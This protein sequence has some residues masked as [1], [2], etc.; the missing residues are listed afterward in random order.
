M[1]I[2]ELQGGEIKRI[3]AQA[4]LFPETRRNMQNYGFFIKSVSDAHAETTIARLMFSWCWNQERLAFSCE[5]RRPLRI[6]QLI[7][8]LCQGKIEGTLLG[9]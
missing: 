8:I 7:V 9:T 5:L 3:V 4:V 6:P 2:I 1:R